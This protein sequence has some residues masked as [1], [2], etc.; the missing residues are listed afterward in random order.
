M[1]IH[2][3]AVGGLGGRCRIDAADYFFIYFGFAV[4]DALLDGVDE[5]PQLNVDV[6]ELFVPFYQCRGRFR[7]FS[8]LDP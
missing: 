8:K 3:H 7:I 6:A 4:F 5:V 1:I 2:A